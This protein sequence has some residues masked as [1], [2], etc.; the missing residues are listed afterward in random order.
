MRSFSFL[1]PQ[2]IAF[3]NAFDEIKVGIFPTLQKSESYSVIINSQS[4]SELSF[5]FLTN[6]GL[7]LKFFYF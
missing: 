7:T 6:Q 1:M 2:E 5:L 4:S 3:S